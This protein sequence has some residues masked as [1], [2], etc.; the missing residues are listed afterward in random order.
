ML[1][2]DSGAR[3]F[4]REQDFDFGL[5]LWIEPPFRIE[6]PQEDQPRRR[7][8]HS[9]LADLAFVAIDAELVPA[10]ALAGLDDGTVDVGGA[11]LVRLGPPA[12]DAVGKDVERT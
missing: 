11:D 7:I 3:A 4:G 5:E 8:P 6:L 2:L 12:A 9:D 1:E 10:A